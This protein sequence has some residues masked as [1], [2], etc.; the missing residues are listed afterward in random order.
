MSAYN[1]LF[2]AVI[3]TLIS[4]WLLQHLGLDVADLG[5]APEIQSAVSLTV[6][7]GVAAFNG[8]W[9]WLLP[10]S[11]ILAWLKRSDAPDFEG[12]NV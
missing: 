11:S 5:F 10:N 4:R 9:V 7:A 6:D 8:F 1:K 2:A 12:E 3:S